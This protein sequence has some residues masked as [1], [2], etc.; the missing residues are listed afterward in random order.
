[1][2][3]NKTGWWRK[4]VPLGVRQDLAKSREE[5]DWDDIASKALLSTLP[6]W[7]TCSRS[8]SREIILAIFDKHF[9]LGKN[10]KPQKREAVREDLERLTKIRNRAMHPIGTTLPTE[11]D[12]LFVKE[13]S[14]R[15]QITKWR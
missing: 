6:L 7:V 13:M 3:L 10:G 2:V 14:E 11:E 4:G 8:S 9:P 5:A 1:M 12:F 15:F